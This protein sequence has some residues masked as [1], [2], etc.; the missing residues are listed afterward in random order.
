MTTSRAFLSHYITDHNI[1][2]VWCSSILWG[3]SMYIAGWYFGKKDMEYLPFFYSGYKFHVATY[4]VFAFVSFSWLKIGFNDANE[5]FGQVINTL[6]IWAI[7]L[8]IHTVSF[9]NYRKKAIKGLNKSKIF[10]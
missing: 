7:F 8:M 9:L 3:I 2:G 5:T 4:L 10:E 6:L 1:I